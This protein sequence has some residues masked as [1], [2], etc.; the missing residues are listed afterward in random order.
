MGAHPQDG[1][2][3]ARCAKEENMKHARPVTR[4]P[5]FRIIPESAATTPSTITDIITGGSALEIKINFLV[6][7]TD[8]VVSYVFVKGYSF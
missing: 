8:R 1:T 2:F 7:L 3:G 4:S 6:A 5:K